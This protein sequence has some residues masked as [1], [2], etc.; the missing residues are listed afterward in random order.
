MKTFSQ[1][2]FYILIIVALSS[3][4]EEPNGNI[5]EKNTEPNI[6]PD[7]SG[8]TIPVNIAPLNFYI[9]EN[10]VA[11]KTIIRGESDKTIEIKSD[12]PEVII[13]ESKWKDILKNNQQLFIDIWVKTKEK[14][15]FKYKTITNRIS[16]KSIDN[17]LVYRLINTGYVL[18]QKMGIYQ[19]NLENYDE[20]IVYSNASGKNNCV[21]CHSFCK[22]DPQTML[23]HLRKKFAGTVIVKDGKATLYNT[24]TPYT[25]T[26]AVYP[27][28]HPN[29][30]LIAF[31]VNLIGQNFSSDNNHRIEVSDKVSDLIIYNTETNTVT[32]TA[33]VSTKNR[34]NM[35]CWSA[36]GKY[37][38]Y[39]SAPETN[40][41][42]L[43]YAKYSLVRIS[44]DVATNQWGTP[45]TIISSSK[46]GLSISFPRTSPD[47]KYL[48][49]SASDH[50]YFTIHNAKSDLYILNLANN[51]FTKLIHNSEKTDSYHSWATNSNW[52]VFTS[53]RLDGVYSRPFI[54]YIDENGIDTKP[55]VIPQKDP[56]F[57]DLFLQNYNVPE[58]IT[59][60]IDAA[61]KIR[62]ASYK[63]AIKANFD[64]TVNIDAL[65][66]ATKFDVKK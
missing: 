61:I 60:K 9:K 49:F 35:P 10:G 41:S 54:T 20:E 30:K 59:G 12:K 38:Y 45:D 19:R 50:G 63:E 57:Y 26:Q 48:V 3:C 36:D 29:G 13:S 5:V 31:S 33:A 44:Y 24:K 18:W 58:L 2:I 6:F 27:S 17:H 46:T 22:N 51:S 37:L 11:Y 1:I 55:F 14:Q 43:I 4:S 39:I 66:G 42:S 62:D 15:W 34:E 56:H 16:N 47:G 7:Y 53:K 23:L 64:K 21:N 8:I 28:W 25:M 52:M 32:T 40:K 65:S